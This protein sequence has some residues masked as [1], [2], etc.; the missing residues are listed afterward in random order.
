MRH[1]DYFKETMAISFLLIAWP[2]A[3]PGHQQPRCWLRQHCLSQRRIWTTCTVS[4]ERDDMQIYV[5]CQNNAACKEIRLKKLH[6]C[7]SNLGHNWLR[8][9]LGA[10]SAP[11][12]YL[13]QWWRIA[14]WTLGTN[15][16]DIVIQIQLFTRKKIWL[17]KCRLQ[18]GHQIPDDI[19]KYMF[20]N[21]ILAFRIK[22]HQRLFLRVQ[23]I[24]SHHWFR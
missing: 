5:D 15:F 23:S 13:H 16:N 11:S 12:H 2:L 21:K 8:L 20:L 3:S 4:V 6:M 1:M 7:V 22:F 18:N 17:W 10:R 14:N 9:W 19:F 24:I